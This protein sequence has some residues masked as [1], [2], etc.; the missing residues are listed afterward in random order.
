MDPFSILVGSTSLVGAVVHVTKSV[1]QF[2]KDFRDAHPEMIQINGH[3]EQLK[4]ILEQVDL[5]VDSETKENYHH[6]GQDSQLKDQINSCMDIVEE[7][8]QLILSFQ[9]SRTSWALGGKSAVKEMESKLK[10]SLDNLELTLRIEGLSISKDIKRSTVD[11]VERL[12]HISAQ[13]EQLTQQSG[14]QHHPNGPMNYSGP[15]ALDLSRDNTMNTIGTDLAISQV[16]CGPPTASSPSSSLWS[17]STAISDESPYGQDTSAVEWRNSHFSVVEGDQVTA[18]SSSFFLA[19]H[20]DNP[21][22]ESSHHYNVSWGSS[23]SAHFGTSPTGTSSPV[24]QKAEHP[25]PQIDPSTQRIR[26]Q[27]KRCVKSLAGPTRPAPKVVVVASTSTSASTPWYEK[28][29]RTSNPT[30]KKFQEQVR[31]KAGSAS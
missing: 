21:W 28:P 14:F 26:D 7:V 30:A 16:I 22:V 4:W 6:Q 24:L 3:L 31:L 15:P 5:N 9:Q 29:K 25:R 11:I 8:G 2:I 12:D 23:S 10:L 27:F 1:S 13:I 19:A 18:P 20:E 17:G